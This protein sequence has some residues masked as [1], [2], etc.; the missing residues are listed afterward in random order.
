[1]QAGEVLAGVVGESV[2]VVCDGVVSADV[3]PGK[4]AGVVGGEDVGNELEGWLEGGADVRVI[5]NMSS[6]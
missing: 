3:G 4:D 2:A 1:M 6:G 5:L